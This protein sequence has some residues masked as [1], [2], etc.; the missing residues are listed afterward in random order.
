[1]RVGGPDKR[2]ISNTQSYSGLR[3]IAEGG[4]KEVERWLAGRRG[5]AGGPTLL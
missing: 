4:E 1:M 5:A 2:P 3:A